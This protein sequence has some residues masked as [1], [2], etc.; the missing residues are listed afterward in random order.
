MEEFKQL[1]LG[2]VSVW[3]YAA[4]EFFALLAI[5]LSL[6][7]HSRKRDKESTATPPKFS[8][9]FLLWDNTKRIVV[10]QITMFLIFRFAT[11][12]IG[13]ELNMGLAVGIGFFL[14]FGIDKAI[15]WIKDKYNVFDMPRE[16]IVEKITTLQNGKN[17]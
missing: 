14:S 15:Q 10:G 17:Q 6:Y 1:V 9:T 8:V 12:W 16:K 3:Y 11:E 2:S 4:A 13:R 7:L 5:I